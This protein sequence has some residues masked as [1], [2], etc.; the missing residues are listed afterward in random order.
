MNTYQGRKL[1]INVDD[2]DYKNNA[3]DFATIVD[4]I[5]ATMF[6]IFGPLD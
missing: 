4:K 1:V 6:G 2:L 3:E 5:D